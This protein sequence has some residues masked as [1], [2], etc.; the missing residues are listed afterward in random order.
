MSD[1]L[2]GSANILDSVSF[3]ISASSLAILR[4]RFDAILGGCIRYGQGEKDGP[5]EICSRRM[6][7]L[8][9]LQVIQPQS[10]G[11]MG[12]ECE[13]VTECVLFLQTIPAV[14]RC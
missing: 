14:R 12:S 11:I 9:D 1:P 10:G 8:D 3:W 6:V 4:M 7:I 2:A 13:S 5:L